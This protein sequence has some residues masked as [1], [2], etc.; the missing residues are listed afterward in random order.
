[1]VPFDNVDKKEFFKIKFQKAFNK[2]G[3]NKKRYL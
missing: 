3:K 1:M 2:R